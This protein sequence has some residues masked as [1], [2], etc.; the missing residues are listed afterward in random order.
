MAMVNFRNAK[1]ILSAPSYEYRPKD[2]LKE[3]VF[4]GKSNV[5]KS[6]LINALTAQKLAYSSK[7]AGKTRYLNYFLID[8]AFYLVDS[9]GYG[10]TKYGSK[11]DENFG[12]MMENYFHNPSLK[13][14]LFLIDSRREPS[15]DDR[16]LLDHLS[17]LN[18]P[19]LIVLTKSD[20]AKQSEIAKA[21]KIFAGLD[22][23]LASKET[24]PDLLRQRIVNFIKD[25][26]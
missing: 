22:V 7:N 15:E 12:E 16:M 6:T 9:P 24:K 5:G 4:V 10:F 18:V 14:C 8:N 26:K 3:V 21:K 23:I 2:G 20:L 19:T 1:Y 13:G 17:S 11:E 25:K